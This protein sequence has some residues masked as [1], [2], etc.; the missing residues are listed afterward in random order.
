MT[1]LNLSHN[2]A[3]PTPEAPATGE[4]E[5]ATPPLVAVWDAPAFDRPPTET[6]ALL[7][8]LLAAGEPEAAALAL[9]D[10]WLALPRSAQAEIVAAIKQLAGVTQ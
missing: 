6:L 7:D 10:A 8:E 2:S 4:P 5:A 3:Q 9:G 1:D